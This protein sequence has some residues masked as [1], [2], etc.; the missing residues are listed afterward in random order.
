MMKQRKL[1][2]ALLVYLLAAVLTLA[3]PTPVVAAEP[4]DLVPAGPVITGQLIAE[5]T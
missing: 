1:S 5:H 3:L 4:G 2:I